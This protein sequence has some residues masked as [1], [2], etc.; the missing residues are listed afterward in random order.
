MTQDSPRH[1]HW[2]TASRASVQ[3]IQ[4]GREDVEEEEVPKAIS[5]S[6]S[7]D[8]VMLSPSSLADDCRQFQELVKMWRWRRCKISIMS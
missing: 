1:A 6:S 5:S 4:S 3:K 7:D 8:A 2:A